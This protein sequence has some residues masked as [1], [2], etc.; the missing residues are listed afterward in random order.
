MN[1][2]INKPPFGGDGMTL[3]EAN[4]THQRW[5]D[6]IIKYSELAETNPLRINYENGRQCGACAFYIALEGK[7]GMDWG[8]CCNKNSKHDKNA[9]FEHQTCLEFT[10]RKPKNDN[11]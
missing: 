7:L 3:D 2:E 10:Y 9:M 1:L 6:Q 8:V 5:A 4:S 11:L